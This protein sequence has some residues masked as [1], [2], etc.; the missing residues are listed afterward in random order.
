MS[1][2][3]EAKVGDIAD[4]VSLPGHPLRAKYIAE[5]LLENPVCYN[6]LRNMFGYTGTYIGQT[7]SVQG[8]G[9]GI[10]SI[11]IYAHELICDYHAKKLIRVGTCGGLKDDVHVRDVVIAQ[12][13]TTDSGI[14]VRTFGAGLHYAPIADFELL[15]KAYHV[16]KKMNISVKVGNVYC[17][18]RFYDEEVDLQKLIKYGCLAVE[19]ETAALYMLA[20][21]HNVQALGVF[22]VSNHLFTGEETT[23]AERERSFDDM[24]KVGLETAINNQAI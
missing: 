14:V 9:M 15:G 17:Q 24:I 10:P 1:N 2:H 18:D 21:R 22:T 7:V 11:S 16:A 4:V 19:M 20:A 12:G 8:S 5:K 13:V 3:I 23:P 6:H